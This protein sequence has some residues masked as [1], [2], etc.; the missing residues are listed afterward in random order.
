MTIRQYRPLSSRPVLPCH[1]RWHV[2][3]HTRTQ[4]LGTGC[5][6]PHIRCS[7]TSSRRSSRSRSRWWN[8]GDTRTGIGVRSCRRCRSRCQKACSRGPFPRDASGRW[9]RPA[10]ALC[11]AGRC[12]RVQAIEKAEDDP[13]DPPLGHIALRRVTPQVPYTFPYISF[14][15]V[16]SLSAYF[17]VHASSFP[18]CSAHMYRVSSNAICEPHTRWLSQVCM[19]RR[20]QRKAGG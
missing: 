16:A 20:A 4:R 10:R 19:L 1:G 11:A 7:T 9:T 18:H 13:V 8:G 5:L 15:F 14:A 12:T 6:C 2:S 3:S 17:H